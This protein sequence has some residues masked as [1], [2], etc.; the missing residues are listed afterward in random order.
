MYLIL[1]HLRSKD[2]DVTWLY[3]P[4]QEAHQVNRRWSTQS[5]SEG[6]RKDEAKSRSEPP[7]NLSKNNS[8]LTKPIL[9]KRSVSEVM[10]QKSLSSS[11]LV[12][13]AAAAVQAQRVRRRSTHDRPALARSVSESAGR[14]PSG[15]ESLTLPSILS[16]ENSSGVH[17]PNE[18][19]G[20]IRFND[21]VEQCIAV[22]FKDGESDNMM[23]SWLN[24]EELSSSEDELVMMKQTPGRRTPVSAPGSRRDS[25]GQESKGIAMLPSTTL[26]YHNDEPYCPGHPDRPSTP[27][28]QS[29]RLSHS[30]SQETIRPSNPTTNFLLDDDDDMSWEPSGAFGSSLVPQSSKPEP[31]NAERSSES[32][33]GLRR[34]PSGM[35]M[36]FND[37]EEDS[38]TMDPSMYG[39]VVNTVN[40][41]RDIFSVIY[42]VGWRS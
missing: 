15:G 35:F 26:K 21:T 24:E 32:P 38:A 28:S 29:G 41:A 12:K 25:I 31:A 6:S 27:G 9:K 19:K 40:T 37:D 14:N 2:C 33:S 18:G 20:H 36:P 11:S 22:D 4:L 39:R 42:N 16:S 1:T 34:T 17:S 10:L 7:S 23:A 3:G 8:F 5:D 30:V 13:Q